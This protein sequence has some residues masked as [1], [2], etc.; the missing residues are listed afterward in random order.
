MLDID[1]GGAGDVP[2][3]LDFGSMGVARVDV[4]DISQARALQVQ[5][6]QQHWSQALVF[7]HWRATSEI[8]E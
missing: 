4:A 7:C 6:C 8:V 1:D 5:L 2:V 3:L